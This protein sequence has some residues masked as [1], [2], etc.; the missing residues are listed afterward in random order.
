MSDLYVDTSIAR[1]RYRST[2][3]GPPVLLLPGSGGWRLSFHAMIEVLA[4]HHTVYALDPPGQGGTVV[5]DATFRHDVDAI[6]HSIAAFLNA[7]DLP[8]VAI[9]GH[10]WGG[11]FALRFAELFPAR[12]SRLALLA[13]GGLDVGDAWEF[14]LM[15]LPLIGELA[16]RLMPL[17]SVRHLLRKS[18]V[19]RDRVPDALAREAAAAMRSPRNR[20]TMLKVERSVRWTATERDLHLVRAPVLL[21]WGDQDRFLP[22]DLLHRFTDRLPAA[23][24]HVLTGCGHSLHDDCPDQTYRRLTPFLL[25]RRL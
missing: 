23:E 10:S 25:P 21:L 7:L 5:L 14:R 3:S 13:P 16:V 22:V 6:A 4:G 17:W 11:G 8:E 1:F 12:V 19:H 9:V 18:F 24:A 15:R 2:G 20:A